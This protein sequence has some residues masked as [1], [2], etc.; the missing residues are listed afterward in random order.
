MI[1]FAIY[2]RY[3]PAIQETQENILD[4]SK[5]Q[6]IRRFMVNIIHDF[7]NR[8]PH[9]QEKQLINGKYDIRSQ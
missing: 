8:E 3:L 9:K 4:G 2:C 6:R 5:I 7:N 1:A